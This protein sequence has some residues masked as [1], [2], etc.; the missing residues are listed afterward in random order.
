[1]SD[2]SRTQEPGSNAGPEGDNDE[3]QQTDEDKMLDEVAKQKERIDAIPGDNTFGNAKRRA[4]HQK[5]LG[6]LEFKLHIFTEKKRLA[7]ELSK[8]EEIHGAIYP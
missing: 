8:F 2:E 3:H 1:M 5:K 6:Q 4:P 7:R